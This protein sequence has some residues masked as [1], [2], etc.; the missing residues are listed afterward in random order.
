MGLYLFCPV[1]HCKDIIKNIVISGGFWKK[2]KKG[3][4]LAIL[5]V[6]YRRAA[7]TFSTLYMFSVDDNKAKITK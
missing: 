5:G 1:F 2:I 4:R 7:Q 3:G 6:E